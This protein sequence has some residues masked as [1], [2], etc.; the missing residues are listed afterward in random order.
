MLTPISFTI[1]LSQE[2][3]EGMKVHF[4]ASGEKAVAGSG[5]VGNTSF[6]EPEPLEAEP[7]NLCIFVMFERNASA[8]EPPFAFGQRGNSRPPEYSGVDQSGTFV[9][10]PAEEAA[11]GMYVTGEWVVKAQ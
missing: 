3:A 4:I 1:P 11:S 2:D 5:C 7:G 8:T 6:S 9:T 10:I